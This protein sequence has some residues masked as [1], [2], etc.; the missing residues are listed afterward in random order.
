LDLPNHL[1]DWGITRAILLN[2]M[3]LALWAVFGIGIGVLIRSQ[4]AATVTATVLYVVGSNA[5]QL[6][7]ELIYLHWIKR[8]WVLTAM[9]IVP[10]TA[11]EIAV[12]PTNTYL[13][14]PRQWV[15]AAVL[16]GYGLVLGTIGTLIIRK[17][18]FPDTYSG[19]R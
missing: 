2:L 14:S 15:G 16:L 13:H 1:G 10:S 11:A 9:V 18:T 5:A 6:I 12:S 3:V 17:R 7:F 4:L 19:P 8:E